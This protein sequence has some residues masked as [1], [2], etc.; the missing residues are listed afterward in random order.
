MVGGSARAP[1]PGRRRRTASGWQ[2]LAFDPA[3]R[4]LHQPGGVW[5]D[6]SGIAKGHAADAV[7]ATVA[8][9]G[10][11]HALVEVGGECVGRGIRPD[12]DPWWVELEAP[13]GVELERFRVALHQLAVAT[14]GDYVRGAHTLN[15]RTG[16]PIRHDTAA[17]SVLHAS[18]MV[19]DAW[20]SALTVIE[21]DA[22]L[23]MA[24]R[25]RLAARIVARS[26]REWLSPAL[27]AML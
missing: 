3:A 1:S 13:P 24:T 19:A 10:Y 16:R 18:A 11:D 14:S 26:G 27:E 2:R 12:G 17:V 4:R 7:A 5:L 15:P 9:A 8:A 25:E 20:A 21:P 23:A 6:L 22:A